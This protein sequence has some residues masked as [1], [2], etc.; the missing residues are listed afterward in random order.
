MGLI[1]S[2]T[3]SD[4]VVAAVTVP[5]ASL[6][7]TTVL[8]AAVVENPDPVMVIVVASAA[9]L[10]VLLVTL[11][12][13]VATCTAA[14][15]FSVVVVTTAVRMP[16]AVGGVAN[17]TVSS[18]SVAAITVPTAPSLN[19]TVSLE[20]IGSKPD[21]CITMAGTSGRILVVSRVTTT[22]NN[23]R[24]SRDSKGEMRFAR[25]RLYSFCL[26]ESRPDINQDTSRLGL[27][28][29]GFFAI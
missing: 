12:I 11:G 1:E 9:R 22:A 29:D 10:A 7:N 24:S 17:S 26:R 15:L 28:A 19:V 23:S 16:A 6:L 3:V 14:P 8:F 21:P 4:C 5:T 27:Q 2:D 20:T 18:V 25:M 13:T